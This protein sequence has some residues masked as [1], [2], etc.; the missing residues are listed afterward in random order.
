MLTPY[1]VNV[2]GRPSFW[3]YSFIHSR[4]SGLAAAT[5][6]AEPYPALRLLRVRRRARLRRRSVQARRAQP[7]PDRLR[8]D[9]GLRDSPARSPRINEATNA[10][11]KAN[12]IVDG[13]VRPV[14]WRGSE[15]MGVSAQSSKIHL[16]IAVWV[17]DDRG[18]V[19]EATGANIFFVINGEKARLLPRWHH[20]AGRNR[21]RPQAADQDHRERG[22]A[23]GNGQGDG[24][25]LHR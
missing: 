2:T 7:A 13:Y 16:A 9:D 12:G 22:H 4:S 6:C 23:G 20:A 15:M 21:F 11:I 10:A 5:S 25:L 3:T 18:Q 24:V 17:L 8:Q 14:A 1:R 19:A